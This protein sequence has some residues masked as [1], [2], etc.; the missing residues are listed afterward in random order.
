[1]AVARENRLR[2]KLYALNIKLAM[3]HSHDQPGGDIDTDGPRRYFQ[4][5]WQRLTLNH[6]GVIASDLQRRL[7]ATSRGVGRWR[8]AWPGGGLAQT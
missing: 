2:V 5:V 8:G 4:A 6:Q 7:K 3:A 1:M